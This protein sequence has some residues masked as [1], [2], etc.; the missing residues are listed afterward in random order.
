MNSKWNGIG[1]LR[2]CD[3][4]TDCSAHTHIEQPLLSV[5]ASLCPACACVCMSFYVWPR[6]ERCLALLP[7]GLGLE[8]RVFT[9]K[10]FTLQA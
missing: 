1:Q 6:Y 9:T 5:C 8:P 4:L 10:I 7:M 3:R 2:R